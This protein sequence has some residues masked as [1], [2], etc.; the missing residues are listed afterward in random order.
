ML[1]YAPKR[2]LINICSSSKKKSTPHCARDKK[3]KSNMKHVCY[4]GV[5]FSM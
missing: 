4:D 3:P 2:V 1:E 5:Q